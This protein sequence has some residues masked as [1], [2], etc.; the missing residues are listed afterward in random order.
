MLSID[1]ILGTQDR[2]IQ[3]MVNDEVVKVK[4]HNGWWARVVQGKPTSYTVY[5]IHVHPPRGFDKWKRWYHAKPQLRSPRLDDLMVGEAV[6]KRL[7]NRLEK[8]LREYLASGQFV[9]TRA[10]EL[11]STAKK[12]KS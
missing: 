11:R 5:Y 1:H 8:M 4:H 7:A 12:G 10:M 3:G 9:E 2:S 6:S